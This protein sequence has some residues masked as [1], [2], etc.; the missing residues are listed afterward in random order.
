MGVGVSPDK[1]PGMDIPD[2]LQNFK[3]DV[4]VLR[5]LSAAIRKRLPAKATVLNRNRGGEE[6]MNRLTLAPLDDDER[7][8]GVVFWAVLKKAENADEQ[9][10]ELT[11]LSALD[12]SWGPGYVQPKARSGSIPDAQ[13]GPNPVVQPAAS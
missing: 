8:L 3:T 7:D 2:L 12:A 1:L 6:F 11:E 4:G 10:L 13:R 5:G 9:H